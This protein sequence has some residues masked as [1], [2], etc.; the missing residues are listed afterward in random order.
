MSSLK[1]LKKFIGQRVIFG[2]DG[3]KITPELLRLD[4]EWGLVWLHSLST[5][6]PRV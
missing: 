4:E 3:P 1:Q 2:F 6:S 5:K